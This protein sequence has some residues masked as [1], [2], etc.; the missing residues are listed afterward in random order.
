[1]TAVMGLIEIGPI[2]AHAMRE[3]GGLLEIVLADVDIDAIEASEHLDLQPGPYLRLTVRDTGQGMDRN[4]LDR[5]FE[6][7]FTTKG[8]GEGAG[9]GLAVVHG[10]VKSHGGMITAQSEL[11]KG[12]TFEVFFPRIE[13]AAERADKPAPPF[14]TG[15]ER[16][17]FVDDEEMVSAAAGDMLRFLGYDVVAVNSSLEALHL[18]RFQ[19]DR[20]QLVITGIIPGEHRISRREGPL[21]KDFARISG[22][23]LPS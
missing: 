9:V 12:S 16:I 3:T 4:T 22:S 8:P 13:N 10:I 5:I 11:G 1:M 17:L 18:L 7:F 21:Q 2:A 23:W 19:A 6:P 15:K 20:F 14:P